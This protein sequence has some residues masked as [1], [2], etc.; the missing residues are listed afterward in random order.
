MFLSGRMQDRFAA[1]LGLGRANYLQPHGIIVEK[2]V[3]G[4]G[5]V[6]VFKAKNGNIELC[7]NAWIEQNDIISQ[8][9]YGIL[10]IDAT[11]EISIVFANR[12]SMR[13]CLTSFPDSKR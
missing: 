2:R 13:N 11:K 6:D 9:R 4:G 1:P 8:G 10:R 12:A 3:L 5:Y 7:Y